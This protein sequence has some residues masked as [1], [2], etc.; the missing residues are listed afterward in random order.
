M[1][2]PFPFMARPELAERGKA[3]MGMVFPSRHGNAF[4]RYTIP[5]QPS[6]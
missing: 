6:P 2:C 3:G 1:F 4:T 5:T